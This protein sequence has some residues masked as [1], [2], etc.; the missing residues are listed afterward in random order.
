MTSDAYFQAD[1][2]SVQTI[3]P[4]TRQKLSQEI[5][6]KWRRYTRDISELI[7]DSREAW[8]FYLRNHPQH[9]QGNRSPSSESFNSDSIVQ[10]G[11]RLGQIPKAVDSILSLIHNNIFP[12]DDRFFRGTPLNELSTQLQEPLESFLA[13]NFDEAQISTSMRSFFHNL[14]LDGTACAYVP[15]ERQEINKIIYEK[16]KLDLGW[17]TIDIPWKPVQA[18]QKKVVNWE[19]TRFES[20]DFNDWRIDPT[21]RCIKNSPFLRRWY[22]STQ[23]IKSDFPWLQDVTPY[24]N[25]EDSDSTAKHL[26]AGLP[27]FIRS[28]EEGEEFEGKDKALLMVCYDDF[29]LDGIAYNNHVAVVLNDKDLIWFGPNPYNHGKIPYIVAPYNP[30]P[31]QIYGLSAVKHAI[32]A[33]AVSDR[34]TNMILL[35][36]WWG[37]NP[38]LMKNMRDAGVRKHGNV[39]VKPGMTL[40]VES[41]AAYQQLPINLSNLTI[42]E[43]IIAKN[44]QIIQEV[45]GANPFIAGDQPTEGNITAF[46]IDQRIQGGN[47]RFQSIMTNLANLVLEPYV[48]IAFE[49]FQ[50]FKTDTE[51]IGD[52]LLTSDDIKLMAFKWVTVASQ[53]TISRN[54]RIAN[55]KA[56]LFDIL[57]GLI[58]QGIV[59]LKPIGLEFDQVSALRNFLLD[60]GILDADKMLRPIHS[61]IE[62]P[63]QIS[64]ILMTEPIDNRNLSE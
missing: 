48:Q 53:A 61:E 44:E 32:P 29:V 19:G 64:S 39:T 1:N 52:Y 36:A 31:G 28:I 22:K 4:D 14:I 40:P 57:P 9:S 49:N 6:Q 21:A 46:E 2:N 33:A 55:M 63:Q 16:P 45:T 56:L 41:F 10:K 38:I 25:G 15:Y 30:I 13:E 60:N 35:N 37:S 18:V 5:A 58:Q 3:K 17:I 7:S 12:I 27:D 42:L 26:S 59:Q 62:T 51:T 34:A 24:D 43:N 8:D 20:L 11:L 50:Q 47:S 23:E 54:R